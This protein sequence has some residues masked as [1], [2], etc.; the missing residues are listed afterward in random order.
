MKTYLPAS[1]TRILAL[2]LTLSL[3][4]AL[5]AC[6]QGSGGTSDEISDEEAATLP[7]VTIPD[8]TDDRALTDTSPYAERLEALFA[9]SAAI[10]VTGL[11]SMVSGMT[12]INS[13]PT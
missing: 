12:R 11:P 13:P 10:V 8:L 1:L 2:L 9:A 3:L 6:S 5:V 7:P 4:C